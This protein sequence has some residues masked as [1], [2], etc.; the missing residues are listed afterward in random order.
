M[1]QLYAWA[2]RLLPGAF[3]EQFG[4]SLLD[5]AAACLSEAPSGWPRVRVGMKLVTDLLRSYV[6]EWGDVLVAWGS[7]GVEGANMV[8]ADRIAQNLRFATRSLVRSPTFSWAAVLL[9]ALGVGAMTSVFAV[10]DQVLLRPLPYPEQHRLAYLSNGSHN[11]PTVMGLDDMAAFDAWTAAYGGNANILRENGEPALVRSVDVTPSF[12]AVFGARPLAGRLLVEGDYADRSVAV[13]THAAWETMWGSDP[14]L[15]GSTITVDSEPVTVAGVLSEDFT[16]PEPVVGRDAQIFRP[17]DWDDVD[18]LDPRSRV[19]RVAVRLARGV[20]LPAAQAQVSP[21]RAAV[22]ASESRA[23]AILEVL[24]G[25]RTPAV[26]PTYVLIDVRFGEALM[27][28]LD[29]RNLPGQWNASPPGDATQRIGDR[30]LDGAA[31]VV[32]RV[33]SA[34]VPGELN[35][36]INPRHPHFGELRIG[37][38]QEL[39]LDPRGPPP[40]SRGRRAQ[41]AHLG[42]LRRQRFT[43]T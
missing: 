25:L 13:L 7:N 38:P 40:L 20:E 21:G 43:P 39:Y 4:D 36:V 41:P 18:A 26:L 33:P 10:V 1:I 9:I 17:V 37:R 11:G 24:A 28:E 23:L 16:L 5:E 42:Q 35:Y 22:Y 8:W 2:L 31:S 15:I 14:E 27:S 12:F 29:V 19:F 34:V 32:I 3:R 6:R 30:W